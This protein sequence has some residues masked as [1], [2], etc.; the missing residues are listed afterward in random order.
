MHPNE[1]ELVLHYYGED[2]ANPETA[3]HLAGCPECRAAYRELQRMLNMV[4]TAPVP[5]P[6]RGYGELVWRRLAPELP[7]GGRRPRLF[8][9][10]TRRWSAA[11]A[12]ALLLVAGFLA[13]RWVPPRYGEA[14]DAAGA[15]RVL[16]V[17][18]GDHL[19]RSQF[20]LIELTNSAA[21]DLA[22]ERRR[23]EDLV[24]ENRLYR[25]TAAVA[26]E[27]GV[28]AVL[29]EL[30]RALLEIA[31][32]EDLERVRGRVQAQG[33]LFKVRVLESDVRQRL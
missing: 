33:I 1:D 16:M 31:R 28:A 21:P 22:A 24:H 2:G 20:V 12:M 6:A 13:G 3:G 10:H 14:V 17:A 15:G 19:E 8:A 29:E 9:W 11:A 7:K 23:A 27:T 32:G 26:G 4:E 18:V 5:E 30:E 25:Q